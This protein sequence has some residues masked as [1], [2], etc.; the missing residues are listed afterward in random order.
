[1]PDSTPVQDLVAACLEKME[2]FDQEALEVMCRA[3]PDAADA[4]RARFEALR[5]GGFQ[6]G[7]GEIPFT[8]SLS[9]DGDGENAFQPI[10]PYQPLKELGRGGQARVY[11]AEDRR[12]NRPVALKILTGF[13]PLSET[14]MERFRREAEVASRLDHPG[15]CTVYDAGVEGG[16]PFIAMRYVEGMSLAQKIRQ[17]RGA[18]ET[19]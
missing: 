11:L 8:E 7:V 9:S 1:M 15:I 17:A 6:G 2:V 10:G 4:I 18:S 19:L 13:G 12:L 16:I 5:A 3:H 14:T